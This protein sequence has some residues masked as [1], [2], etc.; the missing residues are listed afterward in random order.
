MPHIH[1]VPFD[2]ARLDRLVETEAL[3]TF[4]AVP[5]A[6]E[7]GVELLG[8]EEG[9]E[10][11]LLELHSRGETMLIKADKATRPLDANRIKRVLALLAEK[12]SLQIVR[13][14]IAYSPTRPKLADEYA[15]QIG[16]FESVRFPFGRVAVEVGFGSGRHLLHQAR[17]H[18]D[19]LFIGIEIH[20]PSA[21]QVLKQIALQGLKNVWVVNY[22]ARLLLE[23]LPSNSVEIIYVHF[24]VPWDKKPHRRVISDP[25]V[26]EAMRVL[27]VGGVLEL[28]TDS[29]RYYTY[30]LACF[31]RPKHARFEVAKNARSIV[32]SKYEERWL[33]LEKDIYTVRLYNDTRSRPREFDPS[34]WRFDRPLK[35][36]EALMDLPKRAILREDHFVHFERRY[37]MTTRPGA[38]IKC[39]FGSFDRPEHKYLLVHDTRATYYPQPP[40]RSATNL[41]AH[42]TIGEY[43]YA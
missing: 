34:Q 29:E 41:R 20:T 37:R 7:D 5:Y 35:P 21:Q 27:D 33:R 14:N 30:A 17:S 32:R 13:E 42:H 1:V 3:F 40:V 2:T 28:R 23:M 36:I 19:M 38:L 39:S 10:R 4:R 43:V 25:F 16:D 31:S 11:F 18:P 9:G 24:P 26:S 6:H 8:V 15:R 12:M 22:D